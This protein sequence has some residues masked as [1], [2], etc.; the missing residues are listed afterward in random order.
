MSYDLP[1]YV[2]PVTLGV[3]LCQSCDMFIGEG[4]ESVE[5]HLQRVHGRP[6]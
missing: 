3:Y 5:A 1:R 2:K 4:G 6:V